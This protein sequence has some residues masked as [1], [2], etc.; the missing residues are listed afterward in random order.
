MMMGM[1]KR[2]GE[3]RMPSGG[4]KPKTK[5]KTPPAMRSGAKRMG[6]AMGGKKMYSA[7]GLASAMETAKAN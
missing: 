7:G 6:R 1:V 4:G 3:A 5:K 2:G